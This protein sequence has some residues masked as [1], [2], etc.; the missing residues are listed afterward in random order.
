VIR[1]ED[2]LEKIRRYIHRNPLMWTCDRY[3]P[4]SAVLVVN[5]AGELMPWDQT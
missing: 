5:D 3:N 4:E 2:E 1:D